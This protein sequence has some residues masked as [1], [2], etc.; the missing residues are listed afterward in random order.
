MR[1]VNYTGDNAIYPH[2]AEA[3]H[4]K[5]PARDKTFH[6]VNGGHFGMPPAEAPNQGGRQ[7]A[8]KLIAQ[9][10]RDPFPGR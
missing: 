3:I 6:Q 2:E 10:L 4:Q 8:V 5:S 7:E 9:W 1:R